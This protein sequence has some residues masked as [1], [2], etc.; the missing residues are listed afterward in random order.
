MFRAQGRHILYAGRGACNC[1]F[2]CPCRVPGHCYSLPPLLL[3]LLRFL[4]LLLSA[5]ATFPAPATLLY[6]ATLPL[7]PAPATFSARVA[8]LPDAA[9]A[10]SWLLQRSCSTPGRCN[11]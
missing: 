3:R 1:Y 7:L 2:S 9:T 10:A 6:A 11:C 4:P 5:L 8:Q